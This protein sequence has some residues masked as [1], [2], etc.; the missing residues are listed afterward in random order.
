M[1]E[2][3]GRHGFPL[4]PHVT[5]FTVLEDQT[6]LF[7]YRTEQ[8]AIELAHDLP[9]LQQVLIIYDRTARKQLVNIVGNKFDSICA[10]YA[11]ARMRFDAMLKRD[12]R[13]TATAMRSDAAQVL[14]N[15]DKHWKNHKRW[16]GSFRETAF[17]HLQH[18]NEET[19][20]TCVGV[21][22]KDEVRNG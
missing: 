12:V 21:K 15:F 6:C 4:L 2:G 8:V 18:S 14:T 7:F 20:T 22:R 17:S 9:D 11:A 13:L 5:H 10:D 3:T 1:D 19:K 16:D